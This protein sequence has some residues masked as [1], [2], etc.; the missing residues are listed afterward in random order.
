MSFF[1][2]LWN[3]PPS[4][5]VPGTVTEIYTGVVH[6]QGFQ[7]APVGSMYIR[8]TDGAIYRKQGGGSTVYGWYLIA[9]Q[10]PAMQVRWQA[11]LGAA[12]STMTGLSG[13]GF[14][15]N[16]N[17]IVARPYG[18]VLAAPLDSTANWAGGYTQAVANSAWLGNPNGTI[19]GFPVSNV[20]G[21][22]STPADA[23]AWDCTWILCTT[24]RS[25]NAATTTNLANIRIWIGLLMQNGLIQ[26]SGGLG[27]TDAIYTEFPTV[28]NVNGGRYGVMA[29]F[30]TSAADAGWSVVTANDD[31]AVAAQAVAALGA[32]AI[33]TVYKIRLRFQRVAG[34]PTVFASLND[35]TELIIT[36][37][38]V[39]PGSTP[40]NESTPMIPY[41]SCRTLDG[42]GLRKSLCVSNMVLTVGAGN[43]P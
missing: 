4:G 42:G 15:S 7:A 23:M 18:S 33:D 14:T 16:P 22:G 43:E 12:A 11:R 31:G 35:G 26:A 17:V 2:A 25:N 29:R 19:D 40:A 6:P 36:G 32:I 9:D 34:V 27:N 24:P 5:S 39:G 8:T 20:G 38:T 41:V 30:S 3:V 10:T 1:P 37:A 28:M 21:N 13:P